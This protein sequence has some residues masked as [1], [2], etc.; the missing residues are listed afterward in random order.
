ML[1]STLHAAKGY[2]V[3]QHYLTITQAAKLYGV[4]R[5]TPYRAIQRG[6]MSSTVRGDGT[7][8]IAFSELLRVWG[9]PPNMPP[10]VQQKAAALGDAVQ[11]G[12]ASE[13]WTAMLAELKSLRAAVERL[14]EQQKLLAAPAPELAKEAAQATPVP[15]D[16]PTPH[17]FAAEMAALRAKRE[18]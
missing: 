16:D 13:I 2:A 3:Q 8:V 15:A 18:G 10:E 17:P 4:A 14:E 9:E 7:H 1:C 5:T 11:Q 12:A 6:T